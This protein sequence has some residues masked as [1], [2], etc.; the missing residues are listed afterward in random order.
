[1]TSS[2]LQAVLNRLYEIAD[3]APEDPGTDSLKERYFGESNT[4]DAIEA[5]Y[6]AGL[7]DGK[8]ELAMELIRL[9]AR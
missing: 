4:D 3:N 7:E 6:S 9:L 1:M 2:N 8:A 5:G